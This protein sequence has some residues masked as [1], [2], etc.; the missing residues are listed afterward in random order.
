M[1]ACT[2]RLAWATDGN[3][4]VFGFPKGRTAKSNMSYN[5]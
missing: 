5:A 3:A 1:I 4:A 2:V